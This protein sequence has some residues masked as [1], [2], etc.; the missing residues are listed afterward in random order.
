MIEHV[1][2]FKK[3]IILSTGMNTIETIK[4]A[5]EIFEKEQIDYALM[6]TT[7]LY[8][9]HDHLVR[10]GALNQNEKNRIS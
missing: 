7:N 8:Q 9:H 4:P 6:H 2:K 1:A 10:L 3:P 5:V